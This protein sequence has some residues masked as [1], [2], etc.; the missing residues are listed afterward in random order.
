IRDG[1]V[2]GVQT[3]A[4]PIYAD[5]SEIPTELP[6][7][8][9]NRN[10]LPTLPTV[11]RTIE[12]ALLG[13]HD[14]INPP[15]IAWRKSN[16]DPSETFRWQSL[17]GQMFPMVAP[18]SG[19]IQAAARSAGRGVNTPR[20]PAGLPQSG[21]NRFRISRFERQIDCSCVIVV[22]ENFLPA[23]S[24]VLRTEDASLLVRP[25]GMTKRSDEN[26][27]RVPRVHEDPPDL[28]RIIQPDMRPV[29]AAVRGLVHSIPARNRGAHVGFSRAGVNEVRIRRRNGDR[30]NRCNRLRIEDRIPRSPR[31]VSLPN[32][33]AHAS[34]IVNF[35]LPAHA[36]HCKRAP[37]ARW[38]DHPP[39]QLLKEF[40]VEVLRSLRRGS[41]PRGTI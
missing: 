13:V 27:V 29:L 15:R 41:Q 36:H 35:R 3:C 26:S 28:P 38:P 20:R 4:L 30:S 19:A 12:P 11:V 32:S 31:V 21:K 16:P 18:V 24:A 14:Q 39:P 17:S 34:E 8:A 22:K 23:L 5:L 10:A 25:V 9:V 6:D 33:A 40:S 37:P 1:H 7:A 2:T